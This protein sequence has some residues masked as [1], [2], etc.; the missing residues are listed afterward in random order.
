MAN[1][2]QL[3][4]ALGNV[5]DQYED[6]RHNSG[7]WFADALAQQE[8]L[9]FHHERKFSGSLAK[10]GR[11]WVIKPSTYMNLSGQ[12]VFALANYYKIPPDAILVVHDELDLPPGTV[13][14]KQA[15]GHGGH[16]GLKS[17]MASLGKDFWRL[18]IG[19]GHPGDRSRVLDYVLG[20]PSISDRSEIQETINLSIDILSL[21]L[22]GEFQKAMHQ[23]HS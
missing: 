23:L 3:I 15:G 16:N 4:A 1:K 12:A 18:R 14:L 10:F 22:A 21:L 8:N 11:C 17:I 6:T 5:G 13:R 20:R 9:T 2:I 7:F 19:I